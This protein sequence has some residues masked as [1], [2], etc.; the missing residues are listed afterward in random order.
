MRRELIYADMVNCADI[1]NRSLQLAVAILGTE[2]AALCYR[3]MAQADIKGGA[4]LSSM[5]V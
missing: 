3:N 4:S 5:T 2:N 1:V